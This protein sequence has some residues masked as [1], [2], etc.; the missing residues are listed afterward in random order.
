M[1]INEE[2]ER[3]SEAQKKLEL[4]TLELKRKLFKIRSGTIN[5]IKSYSNKIDKKRKEL[6]DINEQICEIFGHTFTSWEEHEDKYLDRSWY[7]TR[8]CEICGKEERLEDTPDE[9]VTRDAK[10]GTL[11]LYIKK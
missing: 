11:H 3:I 2:S 7:Y 4:E 10:T 6:D 9:Y 8:K 5:S 1:N